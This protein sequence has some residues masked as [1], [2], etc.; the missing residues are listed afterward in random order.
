MGSDTV[1][2]T[3]NTTVLVQMEEEERVIRS[4]SFV[5]TLSLSYVQSRTRTEGLRVTLTFFVY[6][7]RLCTCTTHSGVKKTHD[8]VVDQL[9][10]LFHTTHK[11]TTKQVVKNRGQHCGDIELLGHLPN[12]TKKHCNRPYGRE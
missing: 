11:V 10:D 4:M 2:D 7:D 3:Q 1:E 6:R 8:W 12:E 9:D 5:T